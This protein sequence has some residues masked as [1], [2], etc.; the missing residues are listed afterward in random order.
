MDN[1]TLRKLQLTELEILKIVDKICREND[2]NYFLIG[3]TLLGAVRHKGFI[4]W[5]DDID[6]GMLRKD[7][8]KFTKI[9]IQE[10]ALGK[11][12]YLHC[13][14]S[15][16]DYFIPFMKI[17]KNNTTFMEETIEHVNTHHGIFL[18]I[19]PYDNVPKK[20]SFIQKLQAVIVKSIHDAIYVK[21]NVYKL[22]TRKK[23]VFVWF[24]TLFSA[25]KLKK[26]NKFLS[27]IYNKK[28]TEYIV[29]L[30]GSSGCVNETLLKSKV[31]PLKKIVF[32]GEK[33]FCIRDDKYYLQQLYGNYMKLPPLEARK[34]HKPKIIDFDKGDCWSNED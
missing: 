2:I 4:P 23:K 34:T 17:K 10:K 13:D 30:P 24:L 15:D 5:D 32:E 6:I 12:Y 25:R 9:C 31:F 3:G 29:C 14:E 18:D 26:F 27:T 16:S 20:K 7:Y 28:N 22:K 19:F 1:D 8:E 11:E 33:F 21:Y